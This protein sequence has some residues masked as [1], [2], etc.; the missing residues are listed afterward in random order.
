MSSRGILERLAELEVAISGIENAWPSASD[1]TIP[2]RVLTDDEMPFFINILGEE[3]YDR[4]ADD[5]WEIDVTIQGIL[6]VQRAVSG[7]PGEATA[8]VTPWRD[9]VVDYFMARPTLDGY[10]GLQDADGVGPTNGGIP[11]RV[12]WGFGVVYLG[13]TFTFRFIE[14]RL[15]V[16]A[17]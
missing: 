9:M 12:N 4:T 11:G 13:C 2:N 3:R 17:E 1:F 5:L 6:I 15:I 16:S 7:V 10:S 8:A 14:E